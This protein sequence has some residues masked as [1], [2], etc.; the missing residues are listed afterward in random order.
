MAGRGVRPYL[1][2]GHPD[3]RGRWSGMPDIGL[4][5]LS[6]GYISE[7]VEEKE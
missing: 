6:G 3:P 5:N 4:V 2:R 1:L 7:W